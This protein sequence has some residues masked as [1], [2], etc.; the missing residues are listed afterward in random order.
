MRVLIVL[1]ALALVA[2]C[3]GQ[4]AE[5]P[6]ED[7]SVLPAVAQPPP[8]TVL[9]GVVHDAGLV[10]IAG[11]K[12]DIVR[13]GLTATSDATGV[14]RFE[15]IGAGEHMLTIAAERYR[16]KTVVAL[17]QEAVRVSIDVTLDPA[18]PSDPFV[19]T[20][21]LQGFLSCALLVEGEARDCASADDNHRDVFEFELMPDAKGVVLEL[22]WDTAD[23]PAAT[24][25]TLWAETVGY[26]AQDLD[27][28][29]A[30]GEGYARVGVPPAALEKYYPEGGLVRARVA[31]APGDAPASAALQARFVVYVT[32]FYHEPGPDAFSVVA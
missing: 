11:A 3:V 24:S 29:N 7:A 19:E 25:M 15:P 17:A 22:A 2:G 8:Q 4:D 32:V 30:T 13:A 12:V 16:T 20:R 26:G 9:E 14:F 23:T 28:G 10:P 5:G 6:A 1:A 18:P 27:L 21:E 31:L